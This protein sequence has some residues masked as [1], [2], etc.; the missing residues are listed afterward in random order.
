MEYIISF[1]SFYLVFFAMSYILNLLRKNA[2]TMQS[3]KTIAKN[4]LFAS[5]I[6]ILVILISKWISS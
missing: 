4:S 6:Y 5:I 2:K 3:T 1:I